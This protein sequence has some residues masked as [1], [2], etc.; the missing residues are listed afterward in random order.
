MN[1]QLIMNNPRLTILLIIKVKNKYTSNL[2]SEN[3]MYIYSHLLGF[4]L[5]N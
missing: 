5:T 4:V 1:K 3:H 2:S